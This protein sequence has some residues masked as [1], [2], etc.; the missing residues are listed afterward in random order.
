M[1]D[2]DGSILPDVATKPPSKVERTIESGLYRARWML[3]PM[4][5]GLCAAL[6][7]PVWMFVYELY[8]LLSELPHL[9]S[10]DVILGVL[11]LIDLTMVA[12]LVLIVVYSGYENFISKLDIDDA[13]HKDDWKTKVD[14]SS[15]K[16]KLIASMVAISGIQLLKAFMQV[17]TMSTR[18]LIALT[19]LHLVFVVSGVLLAL[20]D[21]LS[22]KGKAIKDH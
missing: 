13:G 14:F 9:N 1:N 6:I 17:D 16:M 18:N 12:N 5:V 7:L 3:T 22:A 10:N 20:M 11:E 4:Y 15:L 19:G 8:H 21:F 2:T